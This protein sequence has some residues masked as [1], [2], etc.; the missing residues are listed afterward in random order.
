MGKVLAKMVTALLNLWRREEK[1]REEKKMKEESLYRK[2]TVLGEE[3]EE[4]AAEKEYN[5][6]F[7]NFKQ[8]F[9]D[10]VED[11]QFEGGKKIEEAEDEED[12]NNEVSK[13]SMAI[14]SVVALLQKLLLSTSTTT[15]NMIEMEVEVEFK[16]RFTS[17]ANLLATHPN[18]A[19]KEVELA[20]LPS[21][22]HLI[23]N[24]TR[25][26]QKYSYSFYSSTNIVEASR[27]RPILTSL[28]AR[29]LLLL[30]SFTE[31]PVLLQVIM[32]I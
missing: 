7:P 15:T 17:L 1:E 30:E 8:L 14:F 5:N 11:D 9:I 3:D 4:V 20:T 18:M 16:A 23:S 6:L 29:V 31:N 27:M 19:S 32:S 21:C 13:D 24:M 28:A 22:L 25:E 12:K 2:K 26:E 10:L